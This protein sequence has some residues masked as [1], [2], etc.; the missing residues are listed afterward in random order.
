[1]TAFDGSALY[2]IFS[3]LCWLPKHTGIERGQ[4]LKETEVDLLQ[5]VG[6]EF[7]CNWPQVEFDR[8]KKCAI[9]FELQH[10]FSMLSH[11]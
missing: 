4:V 11:S 6:I 3:W 8:S 9:C 10:A 1:M 7:S 5:V 2:P